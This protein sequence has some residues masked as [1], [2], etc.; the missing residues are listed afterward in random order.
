VIPIWTLAVAA[1][2]GLAV[3][4]LVGRLMP[5]PRASAEPVAR[6]PSTAP[7]AQAAAAPAEEAAPP[8]AEASAPAAAEPVGTETPRIDM[9]DVVSE[10]ERRYEGRRAEEDGEKERRRRDRPQPSE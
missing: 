9:G 1:V 8:A 7:A 2:A 3:G 6:A 10:L 4:V 5:R